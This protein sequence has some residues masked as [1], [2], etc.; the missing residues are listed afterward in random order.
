MSTAEPPKLTYLITGLQYGGANIG[1][2]RLLSGL[3]PEEFDVTVISVV[4]TSD[5]V[6]DMLPAH[7]TLHQLDISG[8][9]DLH[10]IP[11]LV[12]LLR[13]TDVL[14]CSLF[15]ASVVGV[16]IGK[17]VGVPRILVWQHN[18]HPPVRFR[19][20]G[21]R[22]VFRLADRVLA[23]SNRV[24]SFVNKKYGAP[25][26]KISALP[27]AGVDTDRYRP[28]DVQ[29]ADGRI[30]VATV[31]R[32]T[33]EKGYDDLF[34]CAQRLGTDFQFYIAGDG[35]EREWME[36]DAPGNVTLCGTIP[37]D[38]IPEFLNR[39]EIYFQ[40]SKREG[41][42][43]TVIE[44]MACGLPVVGS[45]VGGITESVRDEENG[46]LC[47]AGDVGCF[48]TSVQ[49][50]AENPELRRDMGSAGRECVNERYS[51]NALADQFERTLAEIQ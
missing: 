23:D 42:C 11:K 45:K 40:P 21:L 44:A 34:R 6:V 8:P 49:R 16:P 1:M 36:R 30:P 50:L 7:V 25:T 2:V 32:L 31:G 9:T 5:D 3:D 20:W 14:V 35:P 47:D 41:L 12:P 51:R 43:M 4:E 38:E 13:G 29:S 33:P 18:T 10:R 26:S 15:H 39:H 28:L 17:L 46:F 37:N 24:S 19:Y 27:I 48:S 22:I